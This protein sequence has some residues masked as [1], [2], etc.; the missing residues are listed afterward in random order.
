MKKERSQNENPIK[1]NATRIHEAI[2][3]P[4]TPVVLSGLNLVAGL[5]KLLEGDLSKAGI[6]GIGA[7][8]AG[9]AVAIEK[10]KKSNRKKRSEP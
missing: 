4:S 10:G 3:S 1:K 7:L 6:A 8:A 9:T 2:M 5:S